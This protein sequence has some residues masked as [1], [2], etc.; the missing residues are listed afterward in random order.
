MRSHL[1]FL[2]FLFCIFAWKNTQRHTTTHPF[3]SISFY[4]MPTRQFSLSPKNQF[5]LEY[6]SC[7]CLCSNP[8]FS[9]VLFSRL[10]IVFFASARAYS[11]DAHSTELRYT[12]NLNYTNVVCVYL[13]FMYCFGTQCFPIL[14]A[15]TRL[16]FFFRGE[17][18]F[19]IMEFLTN[20]V[21]E[22]VFTTTSRMQLEYFMILRENYFQNSLIF[23]VRM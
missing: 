3:N 6:E 16:V 20:L 13:L 19:Q 11:N 4:H 5:I 2:L 22:N 14:R 1:Q 18:S 10:Q 9:Y 15:S 17:N 21:C 7:W 12:S 8:A 23:N